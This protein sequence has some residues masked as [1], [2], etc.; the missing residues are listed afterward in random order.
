M[1][2]NAPYNPRVLSDSARSKLLKNIKRVGLIEPPIWNEKT[3]NI[4]GGHQRMKIMDAAMGTNDYMLTVAKV[5]FDQ[6]TEMEQNVFLNNTK[7]QGDYDWDK[8]EKLYREYSLDVDATGFDTSEIMA[9]YG[10]DVV[11]SQ[12]ETIAE[13]AERIRAARAQYDNTVSKQLLVD[14]TWCYCV[15]VFK[16]YEERKMFTDALGLEDN[17]FINGHTLAEKMNIDIK[18]VES[19]GYEVQCDYCNTTNKLLGDQKQVVC[20]KCG[21][22]IQVET[23][24]EASQLP[25]DADKIIAEQS[26]E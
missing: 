22:P 9:M 18:V 26:V 1:L 10:E 6:K 24:E 13:I 17:T 25:P 21:K 5:Q 2:K 19:I 15:V 12:P 16:Q 20:K 23:D 11:I 3:G 14:D 8:L 7:T 4:V